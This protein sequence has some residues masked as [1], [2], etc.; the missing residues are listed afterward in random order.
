MRFIQEFGYTVKIGQEEA[1]QRW[2]IENDAA[3]KASMPQR[4]LT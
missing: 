4:A 3:L 1:H 2:L